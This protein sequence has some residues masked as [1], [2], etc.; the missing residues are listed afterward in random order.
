MPDIQQL[1]ICYFKYDS[2]FRPSI[3]HL[4]LL[5]QLLLLVITISAPPTPFCVCCDQKQGLIHTHTRQVL[6]RQLT[7]QHFY[8]SKDSLTM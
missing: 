6:Y 1:L 2:I 8:C 5:Y 3:L 4:V 7:S